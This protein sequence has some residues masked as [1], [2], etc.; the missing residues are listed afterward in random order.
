LPDG[1]GHAPDA[2]TPETARRLLHSEKPWMVALFLLIDGEYRRQILR[3][4][5]LD[6]FGAEAELDRFATGGNESTLPQCC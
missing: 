2:A 6:F 5:M 4:A 1:G 3:Q